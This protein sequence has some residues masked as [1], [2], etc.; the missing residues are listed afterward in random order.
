MC[1]RSVCPNDPA[2]M[3]NY[4]ICHH[5]WHDFHASLFPSP[6]H[7]VSG[8]KQNLM[9]EKNTPTPPNQK[10]SQL[11]TLGR[12]LYSVFFPST[13]YIYL[14]LQIKR[15]NEKVDMQLVSVSRGHFYPVCVLYK[16]LLRFSQWEGG[17]AALDLN[18]GKKPAIY[19]ILSHRGYRKC[20]SPVF[21]FMLRSASQW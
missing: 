14:R 7:K 10:K 15:H 1:L 20:P 9:C 16:L 21:S 5:K 18:P 13:I 3:M 8:I 12:I 19:L 11:W 4:S 6:F 2:L 17:P